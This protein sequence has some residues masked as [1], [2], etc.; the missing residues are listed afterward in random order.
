MQWL[1]DLITGSKPHVSFG[2]FANAG[3]QPLEGSAKGKSDAEV[4]QLAQA[5]ARDKAVSY[6]EAL[7]AV[8][9]SFTS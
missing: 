3:T 7:T 6:A 8:T 4:D 5:Y 9:G 2:E 1:Q